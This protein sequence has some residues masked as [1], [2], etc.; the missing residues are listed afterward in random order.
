[1]GTRIY[2]DEESRQLTLTDYN[3]FEVMTAHLGKTLPNQLP[4]DCSD[5]DSRSKQLCLHWKN[6]ANLSITFTDYNSTSCYQVVWHSL[7]EDT[8]PWDCL[9]LGDAHWYGA[10]LYTRHE[11]LLEKSSFTKTAFVRG[12]PGTASPFGSVLEPYWLTSAGVSIIVN[13]SVPLHVSL[14]TFDKELNRSDGQLCL[15]SDYRNSVYH[16]PDNVLPTL[17]YSICVAENVKEIHKFS[18]SLRMN[19]PQTLPRDSLLEF[20]VWSTWAQFKDKI[21]QDKILNFT[22]A[23]QKQGYKYS[24]LQIDD[25]WQS[26]NGDFEFDN[27]KFPNPSSMVETIRKQGFLV[28]LSVNSFVNAD[29]AE[30]A[31][32]I[33]ADI[34]VLDGSGDVPGLIHWWHG[35]HGKER[36]SGTAAV[37]DMHY[38]GGKWLYD[39]LQGL[40][41]KYNINSFLFNGGNADFLPYFS[42]FH[43]GITNPNEYVLK[44]NEMCMNVSPADLA[45]FEVA[46]HLKQGGG[47]PQLSE[48]DS[49][50]DEDGLRGVV[51][52]ALALGLAGYPIF[53][54][55]PVGGTLY[56]GNP[57]PELY[58]RWLQ[59]Q[60]FLP[61]MH[62]SF[63][64]LHNLGETTQAYIKLHREKIYPLVKRLSA[65]SQK[66]LEPVIRPLWWVDPKDEVAL[67][68]DSQFLV[69]DDYMVAPIL[70]EGSTHRQ[71]YI[72]K[73]KWEEDHSG[74]KYTGPEW[75]TCHVNIDQICYFQR[76]K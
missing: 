36:Y 30:F 14:N 2:F 31:K 16:N 46:C 43:S 52:D 69:G 49:D 68:T 44:Y 50:W 25:G 51:V 71:V 38:K 32:S 58:Q 42:H 56:D 22:T 35:G 37:V 8:V 21:D 62:F 7:R 12:K 59:L 3:R 48:V 27:D 5:D 18:S 66:S 10:G 74:R 41:E 73:G 23:L 20:P 9:V 40:K 76:L 1:M 53:V 11:W 15:I 17:N 6:L 57:S 65:D 4:F 34:F 28:S 60:A 13:P 26:A 55:G 75:M 24:I 63:F 29:S 33:P 72:P 64:D 70:E 61:V 45:R 19:A 67:S 54:P 47:L 39:R